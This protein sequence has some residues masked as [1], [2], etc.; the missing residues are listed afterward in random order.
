[1]DIWAVIQKIDL[2]P[3]R[4]SVADCMLVPKEEPDAPPQEPADWPALPD[5]GSWGDSESDGE[6]EPKATPASVGDVAAQESHAPLALAFLQGR[7]GFHSPGPDSSV[8]LARFTGGG[9]ARF[10]AT[11]AILQA[12][13]VENDLS[14]AMRTGPL[15]AAHGAQGRQVEAAKR[16]RRPTSSTTPARSSKRSAAGAPL[17]T[18]QKALH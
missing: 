15:P 16:R 4:A 8:K 17:E 12:A 7:P 6:N 1:M 18:P 2:G 5:L 13:D 9:W 14:R 11:C 10:D 3:S